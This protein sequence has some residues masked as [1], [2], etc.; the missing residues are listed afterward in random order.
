MKI[1]KLSELFTNPRG[2]TNLSPNKTKIKEDITQSKKLFLIQFF[3][4]FN[5]KIG[6]NRNGNIIIAE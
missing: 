1:K 4:Y 5:Y 6:T 2:T 3:K